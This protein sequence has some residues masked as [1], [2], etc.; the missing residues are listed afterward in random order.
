[1]ALVYLARKIIKVLGTY[2]SHLVLYTNVL[3]EEFLQGN[4]PSSQYDTLRVFL[5]TSRI[6]P[7]GSIFEF[8]LTSGPQPP[9][10]GPE[11]SKNSKKSAKWN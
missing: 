4:V 2:S 9:G 5:N 6:F 7:F 10:C 1:M 3:A 11:A 8:L